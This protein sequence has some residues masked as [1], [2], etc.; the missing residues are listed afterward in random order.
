M[1]K[2][3]SVNASQ[4]VAP[5]NYSMQHG[6]IPDVTHLVTILP[7]QRDVSNQYFPMK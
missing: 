2:V 3:K 5:N 6:V 4:T 7:I 1:K